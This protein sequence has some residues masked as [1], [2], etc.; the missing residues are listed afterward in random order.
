MHWSQAKY[1][2]F[3]TLD[4]WLSII[5]Y[6]SPSHP[7]RVSSSSASPLSLWWWLSMSVCLSVCEGMSSGQAR[8][9]AGVW[10]GGSHLW[11]GFYVTSMPRWLRLTWAERIHVVAGSNH[12]VH[13]RLFVWEENIVWQCILNFI[14]NRMNAIAGFRLW[15]TQLIIRSFFLIIRWAIMKSQKCL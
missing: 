2:T 13:I 8:L 7:L 4:G 12:I 9:S 5:W 3:R 14:N 6:L 11:L 1:S 10:Q 15:N